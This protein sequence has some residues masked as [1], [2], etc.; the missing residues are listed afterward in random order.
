VTNAE[1]VL[2]HQRQ[3]IAEAFHCP[4]RETYGMSEIVTAA[5]ECEHGRLHQWPEVGVTEQL[6]AHPGREATTTGDL[7]CTG[8]LNADMPLIRYRVGDR[9]TIDT[10]SGPCECGR[11]LPIIGRIEGRVDDVLITRDG[12][13]I[14]RLDPVF[15]GNLPIREAQI[16]QETLDHVRVKYVRAPGC[17]GAAAE[18]IVARLKDRMGTV[19]VI[20]EEVDFIP[21]SANGKFRAVICNLPA[22]QARDLQARQ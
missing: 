8:L 20:M 22:Q 16:I 1:P 2:E 7:I 6:S 11:G 18:A 19:N 3:T 12:R 9:V 5:G 21:R 4:V 17:T 13:R 15:K 14:G 10:T